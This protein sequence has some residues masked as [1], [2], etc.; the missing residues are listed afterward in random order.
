MKKIAMLM[1][2]GVTLS[3]CSSLFGY[4]PHSHIAE[5]IV[6]GSIAGGVATG[7]IGGAV[8]GAGI[9]AAAGAAIAAVTP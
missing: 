6:V 8:V 9:G 2:V 1:I 3:G 5:G 4:G 7:T